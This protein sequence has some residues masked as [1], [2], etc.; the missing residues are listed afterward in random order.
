MWKTLKSS[1]I[2][3]QHLAANRIC[4]DRFVIAESDDRLVLAVADGHG[5]TCYCR[6]EIGAQLACD[7]AVEVL[8]S[9]DICWENAA[10]RIKALFDRKVDNHLQK[11]PLTDPERILVNGYAGRIAY[12]TTLICCAITPEGIY[13]GQIGDG[14]MHVLTAGGSFLPDLPEDENCIGFFTTS[15]ISPDA[16]RQF[17][18]AY[19]EEAAAMVTL[20]TD[21]YV[22]RA[23]RPW[24]LIESALTLPGEIPPEILT[25]GQRGDDQT[26]LAAIHPD[27]VRTQLFREGYAAQYAKH[28]L[29][30]QRTAILEK[31]HNTDA[32]I[33]HYIH[34]LGRCDDLRI[35]NGLLEKL[36]TRQ[37]EFLALCEA[38][39]ALEENRE[40]E[41]PTI[42]DPEEAA[43]DPGGG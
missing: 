26:V 15:L 32:V 30:E 22:P 11:M 27:T 38:Y 6:S 7:S 4:Q 13:R 14:D 34:K 36:F 42:G 20:Y 8:L 1:T 40:A 29:E 33:K 37:N 28:V 10:A 17:R 41:P 2:G 43:P 5:G 31:I 12:G 24:K 18:W 3:Q 19:D 16:A 21:G 25:A 39:R 35:R 9:N 23:K